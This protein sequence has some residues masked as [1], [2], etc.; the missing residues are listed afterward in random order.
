VL[1]G[2]LTRL[3]QNLVRFVN[4]PAHPMRRPRASAIMETAE[5]GVDKAST[6]QAPDVETATMEI[7]QEVV[8]VSP[9]IAKLSKCPR[10]LHELWKEYEFGSGG[11][12]A[13]KD[14]TERERGADK[15][16]YYRRNVF[17]R[18][19]GDLILAGLSSDEACDLIYQCYGPSCS[20]T[21]ILNKM[22]SD[23]KTG[24]HPGLRICHR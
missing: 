14:F 7:E 19:V 21:F 5:A 22:I 23:K 8:R 20:V 10:S 9:L 2:Q 12:K 4:R 13:A 6:H 1:R 11:F 18:K 15:S 17:W 16:K 3:N 24:G